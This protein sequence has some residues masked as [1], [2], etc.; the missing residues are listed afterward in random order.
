MP[1]TW[2]KW[3]LGWIHLTNLKLP[4]K[5]P[6]NK[7]NGLLL[8]WYELSSLALLVFRFPCRLWCCFSTI[9]HWFIRWSISANLISSG[10][11]IFDNCFS[12]LAPALSLLIEMKISEPNEHDIRR[13]MVVFFFCLVHVKRWQLYDFT[14]TR[15]L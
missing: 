7:E 3:V 6:E 11:F 9:S 1:S 13:D 10:R 2:Q 8:N 5:M 4:G 14:L 12:N 15:F